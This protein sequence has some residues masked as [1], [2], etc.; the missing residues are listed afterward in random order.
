MPKPQKYYFIVGMICLLGLMLLA[1]IFFRERV[2]FS[3]MAYQLVFLLIERRPFFMPARIG[4]ALPQ[5]ITMLFIWL[6]CNLKA[7]MIA[8]SVSSQILY[9]F[10]YFLAY[11]FSKK[12]LLF[13][14][15]PLN[16]I[17]L[18]NEVFYWPIPEV[19]QGLIWLCLYMVFLFEDCLDNLHWI[20]WL[21]VNLISILWI[22][23]LHPL[24]FFPILFSII[25]YYNSK[26]QLFSLKAVCHFGICV[27]VFVTRSIIGRTNPYERNKL[28]ILPAIKSNLPHLF[29]LGSVQAFIKRMPSEYIVFMCLFIGALIWLIT[30]KRYLST[31]ILA[32]FSLG[33]WTLVM[34]SSANDARFYTE[35]MLLP[36][37][38][39]TSIVVVA[40]II[41]MYKMKYVAFI[42]LIVIAARLV[43][44]YKAHID[45]TAHY[46][47]FD[48]YFS[49]A[50]NNKLNGVI[51]D[52]KLVDEKKAIVTWSSGYESIL[53]SS[54]NSPDSCLVVQIDNDLNRYSNF[55]N[56]DTSLVTIFGVW[57]KSKL[58]EN[59][60]KLQG[61]RY[62]ILSRRSE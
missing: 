37:G 24:L 34:V 11:K 35:G 57:G 55:L 62:E 41:P 59:Y 13:L 51:V 48:P 39:M 21:L 42:F 26:S 60:F 18:V 25:Y 32:S 44:I 52:D 6:H 61:G 40:D 10:L 2:A 53:M 12:K 38:F 19:Q 1:I 47:V 15:I 30:N 36:I 9:L 16:M 7:V 50:R 58:P 5:L 27:L 46:G 31:L 4:A 3:D 33:Y 49:Y 43:S 56:C 14:L 23:F 28:D 22:Q 20:I 45:Y 17:L 8:Q 54:I 29:T